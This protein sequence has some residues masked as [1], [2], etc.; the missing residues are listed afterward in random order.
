MKKWF[1]EEYKSEVEVVGYLRGESCENYCRNSARQRKLF[2]GWF[3]ER[4]TGKITEGL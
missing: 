3:Y 4:P 2:K 1:K